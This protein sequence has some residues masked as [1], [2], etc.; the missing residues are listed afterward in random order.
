MQ[1]LGSKN[2]LTYS[3]GSGNLTISGP[4][5]LVNIALSHL[6]Y[7]PNCPFDASLSLHVEAKAQALDRSRPANG[8]MVSL[9]G[10]DAVDIRGTEWIS[11]PAL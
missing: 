2:D 8:K 11:I 5:Q 7:A 9:A 4:Y 3:T 6:S 1:K 10:R